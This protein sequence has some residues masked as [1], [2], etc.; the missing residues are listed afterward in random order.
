[1]KH[2]IDEAELTQI[3]NASYQQGYDSAFRFIKDLVDKPNEPFK[4]GIGFAC[5]DTVYK[6]KRAIVEQNNKPQPSD[7]E[8]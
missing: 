1:M 7:K 3:K 6:I 2:I 8:G 5:K 4:F